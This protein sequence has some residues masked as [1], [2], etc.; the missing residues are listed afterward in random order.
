MNSLFGKQ[1][2]YQHY[3]AQTDCVISVV[4][5][6]YGF[7]RRY[8]QSYFVCTTLYVPSYVANNLMAFNTLAAEPYP[9]RIR[10]WI[11]EVQ[12]MPPLALLTEAIV[13]I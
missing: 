4:V 8:R 10:G 3:T 11:C 13:A 7:A 12:S 6:L 2:S 5:L 1:C 9:P